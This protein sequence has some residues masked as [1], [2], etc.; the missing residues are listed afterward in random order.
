[1]RKKGPSPVSAKRARN[2]CWLDCGHCQYPWATLS[3]ES[4]R[5]IWDE[6][7]SET[8]DLLYHLTVLLEAS[9]SDWQAV[10]DVLKDRHSA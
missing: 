4:R 8:A 3:P 5:Q 9:G 10:M 7:N 1:M 6:V 2:V